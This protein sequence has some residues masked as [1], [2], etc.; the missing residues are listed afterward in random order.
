METV[1]SYRCGEDILI[2]FVDV[3]GFS[4]SSAGTSNPN[5]DF[6]SDLEFSLED[7]D[8]Y[9]EYLRTATVF[10]GPGCSG[11]SSLLSVYTNN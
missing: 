2:R 4:H 9:Y 6:G 11:V 7:P 3:D 8:Y 1:Q 10:S 5:A